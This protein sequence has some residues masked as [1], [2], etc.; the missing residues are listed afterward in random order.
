[1]K[2]WCL[3]LLIFTVIFVIFVLLGMFETNWMT[4]FGLILAGG[5]GLLTIGIVLLAKMQALKATFKPTDPVLENKSYTFRNTTNLYNYASEAHR[6][7]ASLQQE[8]RNLQEDYNRAAFDISL[9]KTHMRICFD[10]IRYH[11][12]ITL[13]KALA[14]QAGV[15]VGSTLL[16]LAG[17]A[18][19]AMP[20]Q[21]HTTAAL[22]NGLTI[23]L[24]SETWA[25][26]VS[27]CGHAITLC[28]DIWVAIEKTISSK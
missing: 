1:M 10:N 24:C 22:L 7:L 9:L 26:I 12:E 14:G 27:F 16:T 4:V 19:T 11:Q 28:N 25:A 8:I 17:T 21:A 2:H 15:I 23:M 13:P 3:S 5:S 20:G 6:E 18:L